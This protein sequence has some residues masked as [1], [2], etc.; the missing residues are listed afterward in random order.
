MSDRIIISPRNMVSGRLTVPGSKSYAQRAI[1]LAALVEDSVEIE[2]MTICDDVKAAMDIIETLGVEL[3]QRGDRYVFHGAF[4]KSKEHS[5]NCGEAG[6]STRLFSAFSL[7]TDYSFQVMGRG[8]ILK[9][10]MDMVIDALTQAG[11][12]IK[13]YVGKLPLVID[14]HAD[15]FLL[16]IDGSSSSQLLTGLLIVSPFLGKDVT[17]RVSNLKSTPYIDMTLEIMRSFG[18]TVNH[19][20]Y[21]TFQIRSFQEI[22]PSKIYSVEGDWSAASFFVVAGLIGGVINI[23]GLNKD[24]LQA[25]KLILDVVDL[26]GGR[27]TWKGGD[28]IIERAT[29]YPFKF[30]ATNC[31][32]L[33]PPLAV[34][35]AM[36]DGTSEI[37]GVHRLKH[38]ESDRSSALIKEL[39]KLGVSI[40]VINDSLVIEGS[41]AAE[42]VKGG[43][44]SSHNDHRMAMALA[45]MSFRSSGDIIISGA[46]SI[47]KSYP[48][49]YKD[50]ISLTKI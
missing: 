20:E 34:L 28:L 9:R 25:D 4:D 32:D 3:S 38:K 45:L 44:V 46:S 10:P 18:L 50:F 42:Y 41:A 8:S 11:K 1:A 23:S 48:N 19:Q 16:S 2:D 21:E 27:F 26:V 37:N 5:I 17:I 35:A 43:E 14:G 13:S 22:N 24:S 39:S 29:L 33:F 31:P 47:N 15:N 36:T 7:M 49:F 12:N 30:D 40:K 6:L